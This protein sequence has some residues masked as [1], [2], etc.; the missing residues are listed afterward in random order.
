MAV[1]SVKELVPK[2]INKLE[3]YS[4]S[5]K[6]KKKLIEDFVEKGLGDAIA[7]QILDGTIDVRDLQKSQNSKDEDNEKDKNQGLDIELMCLTKSLGNYLY[8]RFKDSEL[9]ISK[10]YSQPEILEYE[11]TQIKR[12][13][14]SNIVVFK[15]AVKINSKTYMAYLTAEHMK[16]IRDNR[17]YANF[18]GIQR[19]RR[20][21]YSKLGVP[22]N[23]IAVNHE[24]VEDLKN[25]FIAGDI[26]PTAVTFAVLKLEGKKPNFN[27]K[28]AE[29]QNQ[30]QGI[31][32]LGDIY[33]GT[34]FNSEDKDYTPFIIPDGY[35]RTRALADAMDECLE[36]GEKLENGLFAIINIMTE[37]EA[38]QYVVD[39]FK[40]N[41]IPDEDK[42]GLNAMTPSSVNV[43]VDEIIKNSNTLKGNVVDVTTKLEH[44]KDKLT[45]LKI[46]QDS[47]KHA[48]FSID[49]ELDSAFEAEETGKF[50]DMLINDM[51]KKY[52]ED[53]YNKLKETYLLKPFMFTGYIAIANKIINDPKAKILIRKVGEELYLK[54]EDKEIEKLKL[55]DINK[56]NIKTV[57]QF[58]DK[59]V[60]GVING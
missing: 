24:G 41:D 32:E 22:Y 40:R 47:I 60:G 10:Y 58:F 51:K 34:N 56:C 2:I 7:I 33:I 14:E 53:D 6:L 39:A 38:K 52:F 35:H 46:L 23:A 29:V 15:N 9:L 45:S 54:L 20:T 43:F 26:F 16:K 19:P 17:N 8:N 57:Y 36:K 11:A 21:E 3:K 49:D 12:D 37:A 30:S 59:L 4:T 55:D 5:D 27:F 28:K 50:I 1:Y 42:E 25:R 48:D 13:K 18:Q 44:L 31:G